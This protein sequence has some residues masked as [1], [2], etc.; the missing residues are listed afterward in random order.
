MQ[1]AH[2][3]YREGVLN[4]VTWKKPSLYHVITNECKTE[5]DHAVTTQFMAVQR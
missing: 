2:S 5:I 4:N 1:L 3:D